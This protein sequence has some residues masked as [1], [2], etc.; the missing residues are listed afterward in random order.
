VS[1]Y[2]ADQLKLAVE[3]GVRTRIAWAAFEPNGPKLW[4]LVRR[5]VGRFMQELFDQGAFQG[6]TRKDAYFVKC[7]ANTM[8]PSDIAEG[9]LIMIVGFAD[10]RPAEFL[11]ITIGQMVQNAEGDAKCKC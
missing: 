10:V 3:T 11:V 4:G 9:N 5:E 6:R 7:D 1:T 2:S 8:T